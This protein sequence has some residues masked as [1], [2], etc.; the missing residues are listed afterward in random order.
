MIAEKHR[1][2]SFHPQIKYGAEETE[3]TA[4][5]SGSNREWMRQS[6][7]QPICISLL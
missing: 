1:E 5:L 2:E 7:L 3:N 4:T 6:T